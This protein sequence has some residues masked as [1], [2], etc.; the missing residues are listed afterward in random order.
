[1][2]SSLAVGVVSLAFALACGSS[3]P[4]P[5]PAPKPPPPP[6]S[7]V[8]VVVPAS[9]AGITVA[10]IDE[11]EKA[12]DRSAS[13]DKTFAALKDKLGEPA[14][15]NKYGVYVWWADDNAQCRVLY[16]S[17]QNTPMAASEASG[18]EDIKN[19]A[20]ADDS[21]KPASEADTTAAAKTTDAKT[22]TEVKVD[23]KTAAEHDEHDEH[24]KAVD[25][26]RVTTTT[27]GRVIG[28]ASRPGTR[29]T[30]TTTT[31]TPTTTPATTTTTTGTTR[32][33]TR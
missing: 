29:T 26:S 23:E 32:T 13:W 7:A 33:R 9:P 18:C 30:T 17:P 27:P 22:T 19:P 2:R 5:A 21:L 20:E 8:A 4:A 11:A 25:R 14:F 24:D 31:T 12:L 15:K 3:A 6:P 16:G 28:G 1:M 10:K